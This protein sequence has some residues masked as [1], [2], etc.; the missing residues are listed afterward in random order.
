MEKKESQEE[1]IKTTNKQNTLK[2]K[3]DMSNINAN[4]KK[5][6]PDDFS[7]QK[8]VKIDEEKKESEKNNSG[9]L[10]SHYSKIDSI[11]KMDTYLKKLYLPSIPKKTI[12]KMGGTT[13]NKKKK[14][15][16]N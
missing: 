12:P 9:A 4:E 15:L 16:K 7:I 1:I 3:D 6:L 8:E 11:S 10:T 5:I 2:N 13:F 14:N